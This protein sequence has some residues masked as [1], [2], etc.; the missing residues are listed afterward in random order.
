[1]NAMKILLAGATGAV[2]RILLP[3]LVQA[4]HEVV[5]TTR[6]AAKLDEIAALGGQPIILDVMNRKSTFAVLEQTRPDVVIHQLTDLGERDFTANAA[7]R[8]E[9]MPNFG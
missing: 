2:G 8:R 7:L 6:R 9:G 1:M 5:G 4:E 3:L